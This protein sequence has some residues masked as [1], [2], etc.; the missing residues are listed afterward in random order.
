[1]ILN[2]IYSNSLILFCRGRNWGLGN[3][4]VM[5]AVGPQ[6]QGCESTARWIFSV[7]NTII[8]CG[9]VLVESV[10]A[11]LWIPGPSRICMQSFDSMGGRHL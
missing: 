6:L 10:G 8:P 11:A 9:L 1:M 7:V 5:I 2:I 4:V 3:G